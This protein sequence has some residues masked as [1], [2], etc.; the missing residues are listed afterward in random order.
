MCLRL[1]IYESKLASRDDP[2]LSLQ[3]QRF[4]SNT[5]SLISPH[6]GFGLPRTLWEMGKPITDDTTG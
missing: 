6:N 5:F 1:C 3:D 4:L 2:G